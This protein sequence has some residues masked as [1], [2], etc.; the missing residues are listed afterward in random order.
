M[1]FFGA[2][3]PKPFE[4][5]TYVWRPKLLDNFDPRADLNV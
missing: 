2:R 4:Q 5:L 1:H 3:R